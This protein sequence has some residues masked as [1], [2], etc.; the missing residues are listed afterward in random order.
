MNWMRETV[1]L[2]IVRLGKKIVS[3][4]DWIGGWEG[5]GF[6]LGFRLGVRAE[7]EA[8]KKRG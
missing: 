6:P 5:M 7:R 3:L 4:G 2:W 1:G 8:A